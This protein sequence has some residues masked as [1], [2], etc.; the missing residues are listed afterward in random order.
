MAQF[1]AATGTSPG[2]TRLNHTSRFWI[3]RFFIGA[4]VLFTGTAALAEPLATGKELHQDRILH[5]HDVGSFPVNMI[6]SPDGKF[7]ITTDIGYR[8]AIWAVRLGDGTG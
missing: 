3:A 4:G 7:A 1:T 6:V 8:Q 2:D 5:S